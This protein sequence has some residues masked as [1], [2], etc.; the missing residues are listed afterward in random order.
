MAHQE[1]DNGEI[2]LGSPTSLD[3]FRIP[4]FQQP[5]IKAGIDYAETIKSQVRRGETSL[6][7]YGESVNTRLR[8]L[9]VFLE[10]SSFQMKEL[11]S[12]AETGEAYLYMYDELSSQ[13]VPDV[14][15]ASFFKQCLNL[16]T[17]YYETIQ[18]HKVQTIQG[19]PLAS[20][21]AREQA[22]NPV[23][24]QEFK[25]MPKPAWFNGNEGAW[26][27]FV[28]DHASFD[29]Y[30]EDQRK[31]TENKYGGPLWVAGYT[32]RD[33]YPDWLNGGVVPRDIVLAEFEDDVQTINQLTERGKA[34][35]QQKETLV[36]DRNNRVIESAQWEE[37][38]VFS[39]LDHTPHSF[40][41]HVIFLGAITDSIKVDA[42]QVDG[43]AKM[44]GHE[45]M[46]YQEKVVTTN[47]DIEMNKIFAGEEFGRFSPQLIALWIEHNFKRSGEINDFS[48]PP[49]QL[50]NQLLFAALENP[51]THITEE[52]WQNLLKQNKRLTQFVYY[53]L[54]P[55][56]EL[57][58]ED[59]RQMTQE[60]V[61]GACTEEV[62]WVFADLISALPSQLD[63]EKRESL[64]QAFL[65]ADADLME[66]SV[67]WLNRNWRWVAKELSARAATFKPAPLANGD[68]II[69]SQQNTTVTVEE[70][71]DHSISPLLTEAESTNDL[72]EAEIENLEA[73]NLAGWSISYVENHEYPDDP[74]YQIP[75]SGD[76]LEAT[77][78]QLEEYITSQKMSG[79]PRAGLI[80]AELGDAAERAFTV[81]EQTRIKFVTPKGMVY[82]KRKLGHHR[83]LYRINPVTRQISFFLYRK[84]DRDY[85]KL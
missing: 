84:E 15:I 13:R 68:V 83:V 69:S 57:I 55:M 66:F 59:Q 62:V 79:N 33:A 81:D 26:E 14:E 39:V 58:P 17:L 18:R 23:F 24:M 9:N 32:Q 35:V 46:S 61:E 51:T 49:T 41:G 1:R 48:N 47:P 76:N 16:N 37:R 74:H 10:R 56:L 5:E 2:R 30:I 21:T 53:S 60:L 6:R 45:K 73:G 43:V 3:I 7:R 63:Q 78:K 8:N 11:I 4:P 70:L 20:E 25:K 64:S 54:R 75:I 82:R 44:L 27:A 71:P 85:G 36:A 50:V 12:S 31:A 29:G 38:Q 52:V 40:Y 77:Q 67:K 80:I 28:R 34:A 72:L 19:A 42:S 65:K 22:I